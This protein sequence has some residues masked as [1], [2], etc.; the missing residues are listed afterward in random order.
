MPRTEIAEP[1]YPSPAS[2]PSTGPARCRPAIEA[3]AEGRHADP[4]RD[5]EA[6]GRLDLARVAGA[7]R[8]QHQ[9]ERHHADREPAG[10]LQRVLDPVRGE[11]GH[12]QRHRH[13]RL[14]EVERQQPDR[15]GVQ[16]EADQV[17]GDDQHGA[18]V[19]DRAERRSRSSPSGVVS[20]PRTAWA[21]TTA[22]TP[23][24]AADRRPSATPSHVTGASSAAHR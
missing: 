14:G 21:W 18:D 7:E 22:A 19:A 6:A 12:R 9:P 8:E 10:A 4:E 2:S 17:R 15:G 24:T 5:H 20:N 23:K 3:M 1:A 16:H 11:R 13:Q